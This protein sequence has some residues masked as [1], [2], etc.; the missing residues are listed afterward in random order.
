MPE[1]NDE[2]VLKSNST[3]FPLSKG[4]RHEQCP[5]SG[6]PDATASPSLH[7]GTALT[8]LL[9]EAKAPAARAEVCQRVP[10][11]C[12]PSVAVVGEGH[13]LLR[14]KSPI[15]TSSIQITQDYVSN[16]KRM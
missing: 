13:C 14:V 2:F 10:G 16:I 15:F 7:R 5:Q 3:S 12:F 4:R 8:E 9:C 11:L 1:D 6:L